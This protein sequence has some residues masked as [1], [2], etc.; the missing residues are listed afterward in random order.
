MEK[1]KNAAVLAQH[2][3]LVLLIP[4]VIGVIIFIINFIYNA[5]LIG[6]T[7]ISYEGFHYNELRMIDDFGG[8]LSV[9]IYLG[10]MAIAGAYLIKE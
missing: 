9:P 8:D 1:D 10:L 7:L 2:I 3:G 6:L 4:P 5:F